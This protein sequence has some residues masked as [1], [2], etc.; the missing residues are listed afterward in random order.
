M[1]WQ[2]I[3]E[4]ALQEQ[5]SR[6]AFEIAAAL[7]ARVNPDSDPTLCNGAAGQAVLHA[8]SARSREGLADRTQ[9][10][11][12]LDQAAEAVATTPMQAALHGGFVGVAWALTHVEDVLGGA[13]D[14]DPLSEVD[15]VLL[16]ALAP[17]SWPG[18]YDLMGGLVGIGI[19]AVERLPRPSGEAML[20]RIVHLLAERAER[21]G[22]GLTWFT[23]PELLSTYALSEAPRGW[24]NLGL[25]HGVPGVIGLLGCAVAAGVEAKTASELLDGA[26]TW[27][28]RQRLPAGSPSLFPRCLGPGV[29]PAPA[30][31][32]W[33]YG[34]PGVAAA[35]LVA[36]RCVGEPAWEREAL[37][38]ARHAAARPPGESGIADASFCHGAAG[39]AHLF[40]RMYQST[41]D[42]LLARASRLWLEQTLAMR[43]PGCGVG[44]YLARVMSEA[45]QP[46]WEADPGIL[47]GAAG[48]ALVL[49][50]ACTSVAPEWDRMFLVSAKSRPPL[51]GR[52]R[53]GCLSMNG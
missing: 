24:H 3:A 39:L 47:N 31:A 1:V 6:T 40:N 52:R 41:G 8:Y 49:L 48:V 35:L 33:C 11:R 28:L 17:S 23:A 25:A 16:Q 22:Q 42:P 26:V 13:G 18:T 14:G 37:T 32:A 34:D 51:R 43:R 7:A 46:A 9:A 5:L 36:A 12:L 19:Y 29:E 2:P 44:G 27:L 30:R 45:G 50:A 4:G 38:I 20:A 15:E 53:P 21:T 10:V